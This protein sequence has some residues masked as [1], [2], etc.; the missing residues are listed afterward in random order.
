MPEKEPNAKQS[1]KLSKRH[2]AGEIGQGTKS[3]LKAKY[4]EGLNEKGTAWQRSHKA[5]TFRP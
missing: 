3:N 5:K 1:Q 4:Q 2:K